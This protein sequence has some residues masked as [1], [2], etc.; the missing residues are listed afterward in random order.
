MLGTLDPRICN[1]HLD[2]NALDRDDSARCVFVVR[3]LALRDADEIC[4]TIPKSVRSE[5]RHS[6]TPEKVKA[7]MLSEIYTL[8]ASP[9]AKEQATL[10]QIRAILTG[11][12]HAGKHDDDAEHLFE[13]SKYGGG[14]FITHDRRML[15]KRDELRRLLSPA[16]TIV[17]LEEFLAAYDRFAATG[18]A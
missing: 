15:N 10:G 8:E 13:A 6:H 7:D 12:A 3:V 1:I 16:L 2:A 18:S 14:Y 5:V 4:F 17:T 11:N 9:T